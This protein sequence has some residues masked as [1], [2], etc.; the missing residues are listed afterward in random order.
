MMCKGFNFR[1]SY[2]NLRKMGFQH[3]YDRENFKL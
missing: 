2:E 3:A 1:P